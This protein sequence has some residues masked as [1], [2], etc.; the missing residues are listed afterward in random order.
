MEACL[1]EEVL[2]VII[3]TNST[4]LTRKGLIPLVYK[5][6]LQLTNKK[7]K[8]IIENEQIKNFEN[9]HIINEKIQVDD[10]YKNILRIS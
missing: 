3:L 10:K 9:G 4:N 5:E 6:H 1:L 8:K 2:L 7:E